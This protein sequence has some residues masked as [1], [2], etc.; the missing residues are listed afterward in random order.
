MEC[1]CR[2]NENGKSIFREALGN[3]R[4]K[5]NVSYHDEFCDFCREMALS[6]VTI[7][8]DATPETLC[9]K[10]EKSD[11][12]FQPE[13]AQ[14]L[15]KYRNAE[16]EIWQTLEAFHQLILSYPEENITGQTFTEQ[17]SLLILLYWLA[18]I[19]SLCK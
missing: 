8:Q 9:G 3:E 19:P 14:N 12:Y 18:D 15:L 17:E 16:P 6:P 7:M 4:K 1:Y 11:F 2:L 10:L 5:W 13:D